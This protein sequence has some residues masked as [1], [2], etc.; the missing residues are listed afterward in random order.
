MCA[1]SNSFPRATSASQTNPS[2]GTGNSG[3][4]TKSGIKIPR[5]GRGIRKSLS[6]L[7]RVKGVEPGRNMQNHQGVYW[8]S[9]TGAPK[10]ALSRSMSIPADPDLAELVVK[11]DTVPV[12]IRVGILAMVRALS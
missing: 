4:G 12:A 11:W 5:R 8:V 3:I 9:S 2:N 7:E 1:A 10:A 6:L